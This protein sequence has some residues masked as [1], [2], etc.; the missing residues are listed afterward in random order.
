ML[1]GWETQLG[2]EEH[3]IPELQVPCDKRATLQNVFL[4]LH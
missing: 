1:S 3:E 4:G 2:E